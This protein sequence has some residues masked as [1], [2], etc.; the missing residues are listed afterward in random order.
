MNLKSFQTDSETLAWTALASAQGVS[1]KIWL[2]A[3]EYY[4][5]SP[6]ELALNTSSLPEDVKK[7]TDQISQPLID[8][9]LKWNKMD[10]NRHIIAYSSSYYP[11]SL[12]QLDSPPLVLFATGNCTLLQSPQIAIVGSRRASLQGKRIANDIG[13]GL[14][15]YGIVVTSGL[16]MGI[17]CAAHQGALS[18]STGTI[19]VMGTG[20]EIVYPAKNSKLYETINDSGGVTVTEFFPGQG[21]KPWHFP[22][23]NRIIAALSLGTLVVE[24]KI[25]SG[26]L[27][28]ANLAADMGREVFAVPGNIFHAY[29][30]G[31]HWLIQQGAKLVTNIN[32]ILDE[33]GVQPTQLGLNVD[34][35]NEKSTAN[36][37]ATDKLLASV[38]YDITAID[39]IAQRN[40]LSVSQAMASLLE[41]ELRGLVAAVP[42]GYVKLRGK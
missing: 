10:E 9:A 25:K 11:E 35:Q 6:E 4:Q 17:D 36:S 41:Y 13:F 15:E 14:S 22:R 32:D 8:A 18:G 30:E 42:G 26:T 7:L 23:R 40:A 33:I 38:D 27:I 1:S 34:Q 24:A 3:I 19:A 29:S 37:L 39:V 28:T 21:P 31:C 12:K 2:Q 20:P 16:A 5:L